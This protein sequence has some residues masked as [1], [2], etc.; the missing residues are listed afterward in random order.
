MTVG[1][2]GGFF[3]LAVLWVGQID[4]RV[5]RFGMAEALLSQQMIPDYYSSL[6]ICYWN[7]VNPI[8]P[9]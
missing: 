5:E 1:L 2:G 7:S 9:I 3:F 4:V 6:Y 8:N